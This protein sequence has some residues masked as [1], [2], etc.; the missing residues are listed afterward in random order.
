MEFHG[1]I[2]KSCHR[3]SQT[4]RR[5]FPTLRR[6]FQEPWQNSFPTIFAAHGLAESMEK[7]SF[8]LVRVL[9]PHL[10]QSS[11]CMWAIVPQPSQPLTFGNVIFG[12]PASNFP[13]YVKKKRRLGI[14]HFFCTQHL[15]RYV[16]IYICIEPTLKS[17]LVES[18]WLPMTAT[19]RLAVLTCVAS[20]EI[21]QGGPVDG[22]YHLWTS[23]LVHQYHVPSGYD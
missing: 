4:L 17:W 6:S 13:G 14:R 22:P 3:N 18:P 7:R 9:G 11:V 20:S 23:L 5:N 15:S 19:G 16:Y 10:C 12:C 21:Q 8:V 1:N 2:T